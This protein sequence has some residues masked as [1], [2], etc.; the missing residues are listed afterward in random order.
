MSPSSTSTA[1]AAPPAASAPATAPQAMATATP[2][3]LVAPVPPAAQT[4]TAQSAASANA[5]REFGLGNGQTRIVIHAVG[6]SWVLVHDKD[7][8]AIFTRQLHAGDNYHVPNLDGLI[9]RTGSA[10][11]LAVTVDGHTAPALHGGVQSNIL[12]DADRLMAGTAIG[13]PVA[14]RVPIQTPAVPVTTSGAPPSAAVETA[15]L[16]E[17]PPSPAGD[18]ADE[19]QVE[20]PE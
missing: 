12:L 6:D 20:H 18:P 2:P 19:P 15:P 10:N 4:T 14:V 8:H 11:S 1:S 3:A 9:M 17:P 5:M 7:N 16:A 13:R